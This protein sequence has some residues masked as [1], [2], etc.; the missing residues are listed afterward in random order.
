MSKQ[1]EE[2]MGEVPEAARE[3]AERLANRSLFCTLAI[4]TDE[5]VKQ[6]DS[7]SGHWLARNNAA[8]DRSIRAELQRESRQR[9]AGALAVC[10]NLEKAR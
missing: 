5:F 10:A 9:L 7:G 8:Q 4:G 1:A 3:E 6:R 2:V